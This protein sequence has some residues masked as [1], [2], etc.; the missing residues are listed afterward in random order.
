MLNAASWTDYIDLDTVWD[1][2]SGDYPGFI[3]DLSSQ[4]D[5]VFN[6]GDIF[7]LT[8]ITSTGFADSGEDVEVTVTFQHV[9]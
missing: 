1:S 8:A 6:V 5:K 2:G 3:E 7:A 9:K 4:V